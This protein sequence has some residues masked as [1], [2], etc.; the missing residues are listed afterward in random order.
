MTAYLA[1]SL[2]TATI[3]RYL[4]IA[5][6]PK[7]SGNKMQDDP[8]DWAAILTDSFFDCCYQHVNVVASE[9]C[10]T[11]CRRVADSRMFDW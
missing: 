6:T 3:Y 11:L 5:L 1:S 4:Q 10:I 2:H 8:S 9:P 7:L